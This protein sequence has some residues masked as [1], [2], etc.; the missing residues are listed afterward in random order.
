MS[1]SHNSLGEDSITDRRADKQTDGGD[2][3]ISFAFLKK[4]GDNKSLDKF[5]FGQDYIT[6]TELAA[7]ERLKNQRILLLQL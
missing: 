7:L 1:N 3:N 4:Y 2:Y 6:S 5:E